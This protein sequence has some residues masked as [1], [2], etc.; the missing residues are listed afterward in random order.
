V[1]PVTDPLRLRKFGSAGNRTQASGAKEIIIDNAAYAY[2][3][4]MFD[5]YELLT[6][7]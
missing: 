7:I 3:V 1:D 2:H 6:V 4:S 5:W